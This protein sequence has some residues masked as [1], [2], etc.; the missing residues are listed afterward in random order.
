MAG[1]WERYLKPHWVFI[2]F[3]I[4]S[5]FCVSVTPALGG[6]IVLLAVATFGRGYA[7]GLSQPVMFGI[8]SRAVGRSQ[9]GTSIGL[10]TTSN[11]FA[12]LVVPAIMGIVADA[13]GIE[14]SFLWVGG[15]LI[16]L[17]LAVAL[18]VRRI[19]GFR[20]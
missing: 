12:S 15:V 20:T 11:R 16:V 2:L 3:V 6:L 13:V 8:L 17:C 5:I 1:F 7:Q 18:L 14:A 4:M 9:Q 10:R 19:P